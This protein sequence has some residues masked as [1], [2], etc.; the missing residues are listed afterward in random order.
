[1][2]LSDKQ[3]IA[4]DEYLI[5]LNWEKAALKA[6]YA[7][8]TA[9]AK[10]FAWVG[11]SRTDSMFP[12]MWDYIERKRQKLARSYEIS[13]EILTAELAKIALASAKDLY[14]DDGNYIDIHLL[15]DNVAA[16]ISS[17]KVLEKKTEGKGAEKTTSTVQ[18]VKRYDK[19]AAIN[20][21][22]K[23]MGWEAAQKHQHDAG[24]S[25]LDFL[26]QS[27]MQTAPDTQ[28][29]AKEEEEP[30]KA[31]KPV[32]KNSAPKKPASGKK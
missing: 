32:K 24:P 14:D 17:V 6:G 25:F 27:T 19:I 21:I 2:A 4:C 30:A 22:N 10:S 5:C 11:K 15:D 16:T 31:R 26:K 23:M 8:S 3:R 1:M 13:R 18:E 9:R 7:A 28:L 12:E 20:T 29:V